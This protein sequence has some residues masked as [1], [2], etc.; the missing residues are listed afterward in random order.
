MNVEM[1]KVYLCSKSVEMLTRSWDDII[2]DTGE[3]YRVSTLH[4]WQVVI[5]SERFQ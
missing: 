4:R 5:K 3:A 1:A 2:D